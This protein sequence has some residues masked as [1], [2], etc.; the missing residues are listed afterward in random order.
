MIGETVLYSKTE[1]TKQICRTHPQLCEWFRACPSTFY[2]TSPAD[3]RADE[4]I[5]DD[6]QPPNCFSVACTSSIDLVERV[7]SSLRTCS[8]FVVAVKD[9]F[10]RGRRCCAALLQASK[11]TRRRRGSEQKSRVSN[12]LLSLYAALHL[13]REGDNTTRETSRDTCLWGCDL[14][15]RKTRRTSSIKRSRSS[16]CAS[17]SCDI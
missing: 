9:T 3:L 15:G 6:K 1:T 4:A 16:G 17:S 10:Q 8:P 14:A 7:P 13:P 5:V 12:I 11:R 2:A